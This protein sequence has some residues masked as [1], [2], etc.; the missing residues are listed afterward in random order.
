MPRYV[1]TSRRPSQHHSSRST[2]QAEHNQFDRIRIIGRGSQGDCWL[3]RTIREDRLVVRKVLDK[4]PMIRETTLEVR[5]LNKILPRHHSILHIFYWSFKDRRLE[6]YYNYCA[7]GSLDR[8]VPKANPGS[9]SEGFIWHVFVQL[10]EALEALHYRDSR[11]IVHRDVKPGNVFLASPYIPGSGGRPVLKLGYLGV[12]TLDPISGFAGATI[13]PSPETE[14]TARGDVWGFGAVIHA[15][16]HGVGPVVPLPSSAPK[17]ARRRSN[18]NPDARRPITLPASFFDTL[19]EICIDTLSDT[20]P[21]TPVVYVLQESNQDLAITLTSSSLQ[22]D[23]EV[24]D[25]YD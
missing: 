6:L 9:L 24:Q 10:A 4:Y 15:L 8:L 2:P 23:R 5:I 3:M 19:L 16:A 1:V 22:R 7:G 18:R 14:S 12:A 21:S 11:R 25:A 17:E 20:L 13:C